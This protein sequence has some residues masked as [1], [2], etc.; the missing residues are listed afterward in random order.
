MLSAFKN[1][2]VTLIIAL[3]IFGFGA[4]FTSM[5]LN[6]TM[7]SILSSEKEQLDSIV[8]KGE[9]EDPDDGE[10][11]VDPVNPEEIIEGESFTFLLVVTDYRPDVYGDYMPDAVHLTA[12]QEEKKESEETADPYDVFGPLSAD[13]RKAG[14]AA[15]VLVSADKENKQ[16]T[17]TYFSPESRMYTPAGYHTLGDAYYY[18]GTQTLA[19]HIHALTGIR[20]D[21]EIT[22]NGY[23]LD[24]IVDLLGPVTVTLSKDIFHDGNAY[25]TEYER[26]V[27]TEDEDGKTTSEKVPNTYVLGSGTVEADRETIGILAEMKERSMSDISMKESFTVEFVKQYLQKIGAME[28]EDMEILLAMMTLNESD[29]INIEGVGEE[30]S[31]GESGMV[32]VPPSENNPW[33][34]DESEVIPA[35]TEDA[36]ETTDGEETVYLFEPETP[37]LETALAAA[38]LPGIGGVLRAISLFEQ[39]T[40]PYPG[41]FVEAKDDTPAYFELNTKSGLSKFLS[42]R[43]EK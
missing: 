1:F 4:Y 23:N 26:T 2:A 8:S 9:D 14:A 5:F 19:E 38:D 3:L 25:T 35:E 37:I 40:E 13:Y 32:T 20:P 22:V 12:Q 36:A 41:R 24:E 17:Y 10:D 6:N 39:I 43:S 31:D 28:E 27:E 42:I 34:S 7:N 30:T 15:I 21:Y 11:P 33:W 29:W 18:Y 16:Y